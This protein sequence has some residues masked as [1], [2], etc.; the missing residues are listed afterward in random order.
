MECFR[1]DED[2]GQVQGSVHRPSASGTGEGVPL[3]SLH[4]HSAEGGIG[5]EPGTLRKT[6]EYTEN[7]SMY[8]MVAFSEELHLSFVNITTAFEINIWGR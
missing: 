8:T 3:Q 7:C 5:H 6:S 4:H 1:K 2:E